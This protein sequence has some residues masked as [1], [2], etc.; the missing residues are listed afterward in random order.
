MYYM[1]HTQC[2][3]HSTQVNV[4]THN[5]TT[6][7]QRVVYLHHSLPLLEEYTLHVERREQREVSA[8][9]NTCQR[10]TIRHM[11]I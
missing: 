6:E 7:S 1:N 5:Y 8:H 3:L 2:K 10:C 9:V 4:Q 11:Y